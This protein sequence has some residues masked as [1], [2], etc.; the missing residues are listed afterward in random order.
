MAGGHDWAGR[1]APGACKASW[2]P[3]EGV[4]AELLN[5]KCF[6]RETIILREIRA[7][8]GVSKQPWSKRK[9]N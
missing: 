2:Q 5:R 1:S 8:V 7:Q 3:G 4:G 9:L 6:G